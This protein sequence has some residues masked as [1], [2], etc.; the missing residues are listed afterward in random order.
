M[1]LRFLYIT[2]LQVPLATLDED[3]RQ[4]AAQHVTIIDLPLD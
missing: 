3:Q 1:L 4:R 2:R